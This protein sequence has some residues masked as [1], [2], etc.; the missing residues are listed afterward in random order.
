MDKYDLNFSFLT[1]N[2]YLG[3]DLTP[4]ATATPAQ[5]PQRVTEV[6]RQFLATNFPVRVKA[7]ACEIAAKNPDLIGLQEAELWQLVIP[8]FGIVTYDFI[9]LLLTELEAIG[10][11]YEI[12]A[13]NRNFSTELPDSN[14]NLVRFLDRDAILIRKRCGLE[15]INKQEANYEVNLTVQI[16]GQTF[17]ILHGWSLVDIKSDGYIFR[18]INT[19]LQPGVP[20][21]QVAQATELLAGP[22]NTNLPV[23]V[24]GDLNSN[25]D[26]SGTPT[27]GM[28]ISA[29][30]H[31]VW[32]EVG[33]GPGV[34][35]CQAPDLLNAVSALNNRI[36]FILFKNGWEAN[37]ADLVGEEQDDRTCTGLWPSDHAGVAAC[38][39]LNCSCYKEGCK[40]GVSRSSC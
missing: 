32:K 18:M 39:D 29:G 34:T 19:H 11:N 28:F 35:C 38:L 31:D 17:V 10:L 33:K 21:I 2:I 20:S 23:V 37:K 25:A 40:P 6:F 24:T 3:A 4:L 15:V 13:Q 14:G 16:A 7:I 1:W 22:A 12:A 36:D 5:L 30:F 27:Y 8:K 9:Q 26:G